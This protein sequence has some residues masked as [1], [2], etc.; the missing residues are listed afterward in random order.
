[1][2][3]IERRYARLVRLY[4]ARSPRDEIL[5][6]LLQSGQPPTMRETSALVLGALRARAGYGLDRSPIRLAA[7]AV[8]LYAAAVDVLTSLPLDV[9][10]IVGTPLGLAQYAVAG[11]AALVLHVTALF[12]LARGAYRL[13]AVASVLAVGP[14]LV[15][16]ERSG[17]YLNDGFWAAPV[18]ALLVLAVNLGPR[19]ERSSPYLWMALLPFA[20][21]ILPTGAGTVLWT[22]FFIQ[23]QAMLVLIVIGLAWS[24]VDPRVPLA[25]AALALCN[26]LTHVTA[27]AAGAVVGGGSI[28]YG[29]AVT[30]VPWLLLLAAA[31]VGHRRALI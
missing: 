30:A 22:S 8:L 10:A 28:V 26:F 19:R 29:L 18:A 24:A 1:M 21:V 13:S 23:Q 16:L 6:T 5:D 20:I 17:S 14:A 31:A 7:L 9:P 4:P 12:A 3:H 25:V 27:V 11:L 15:A 2:N